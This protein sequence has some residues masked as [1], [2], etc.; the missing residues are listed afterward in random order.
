MASRGAGL[1]LALALLAGCGGVIPTPRPT[2]VRSDRPCDYVAYVA[3]D[4][5]EVQKQIGEAQFAVYDA[6]RMASLVANVQEHRAS[7]VNRPVPGGLQAVHDSALAAA[8]GAA[9]VLTALQEQENERAAMAV[10]VTL[11]RKATAD[12]TDYKQ[13]LRCY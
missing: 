6:G 8:G 7:I 3:A 10:Y 4:L 1:L 5:A 9:N 13:R 12:L 11:L 2:S